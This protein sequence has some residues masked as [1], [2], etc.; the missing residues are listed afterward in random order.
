MSSA[1]ASAWGLCCADLTCVRSGVYVRRPGHASQTQ[2]RTSLSV[3]TISSVCPPGLT[4]FRDGSG[5]TD[6][7]F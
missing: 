4:S 5:G 2:R 3:S 7:D 1:S 6:A